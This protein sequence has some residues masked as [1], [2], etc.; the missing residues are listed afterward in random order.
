MWAGDLHD[1]DV[2]VFGPR[3]AWRRISIYRLNSATTSLDGTYSIQLS[4]A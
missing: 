1:A 4:C 2:L 3:P